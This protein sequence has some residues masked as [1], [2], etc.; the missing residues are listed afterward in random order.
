MI[1][2]V[3]FVNLLE[4]TARSSGNSCLQ[5]CIVK[6]NAQITKVLCVQPQSIDLGHNFGRECRSGKAATSVIPAENSFTFSVSTDESR[7]GPGS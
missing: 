6:I 1:Y 3:R 2:V 5:I 4:K 7:T